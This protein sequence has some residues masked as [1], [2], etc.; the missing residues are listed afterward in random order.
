MNWLGARH[1]ST[2]L[3]LPAHWTGALMIGLGAVLAFK[4]PIGGG[5]LILAGLAVLAVHAEMKRR[6]QRVLTSGD[7]EAVLAAWAPALERMPHPGT[8]GPVI[9]ATAF[10]AHGQ[11][12]EA[13]QHL[14]RAERGEAWDA[15]REQRL[16]IE[17]LIDAFN[18]DRDKAVAQAR[19]LS[20]LPLPPAGAAV[21][22]QIA[23]IRHAV[24]AV[25]RA[26]AHE[27]ESED[28]QAL[29]LA[30]KTAPILHWV[31]RYAAAVVQI[32]R[33][34]R[35]AAELLLKGAP[36]WPE[37]SVFHNFHRELLDHASA[38][39]EHQVA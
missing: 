6:A 2:F 3:G 33:G 27:S 39:S 32:D 10:I 23:S 34:E 28:L 1:Q 38:P 25:A 36:A 15:T 4:V 14:A 37:A 30:S 35:R 29:E 20:A 13:E 21:G 5:A 8:L 7:P 11:T 19:V 17:T 9:T 16:L 22:R 18:G 12:H 31:T 24:S 26:F